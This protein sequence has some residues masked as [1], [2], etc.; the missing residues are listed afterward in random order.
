MNRLAVVLL[1]LIEESVFV[2]GKH[3]FLPR[4]LGVPSLHSLGGLSLS[5]EGSTEGIND[6][7]HGTQ[8]FALPGLLGRRQTPW[9]LPIVRDQRGSVFGNL[10]GGQRIQCLS[11]YCLPEKTREKGRGGLEHDCDLQRGE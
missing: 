9:G 2:L 11:S 6:L 1:L 3:L 8:A 10:G 4:H 5:R 7:V